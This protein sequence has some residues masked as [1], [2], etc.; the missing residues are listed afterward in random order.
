MTFAEI[1]AKILRDAKALIEQQGWR[2]GL[3]QDNNIGGFPL[4]EYPL[5]A[6]DA[7]IKAGGII[8]GRALDR[9]RLVIDPA[10]NTSI[11]DWNDVHSR[12]LDQVNAAFDRAIAKATEQP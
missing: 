12:T 8:S 9:M 7:I 11:I 10:N 6:Y 4:W 1:D 2:S 3:T 5:C